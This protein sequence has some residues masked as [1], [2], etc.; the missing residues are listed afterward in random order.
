MPTYLA[1]SSRVQII[2]TDGTNVGAASNV[3]SGFFN[4]GMKK[5]IRIG[6]V[7]VGATSVYAFEI[8]W[9]RDGSSVDFTETV[10]VTDLSSVTKN[11]AAPFARFRIRNT[12]AG[13]FTSHRTNVMA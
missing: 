9:S 3:V 12:G 4:L 2:W 7:S 8:D 1:L 11:V 13:A 5:D 10:V 6:K